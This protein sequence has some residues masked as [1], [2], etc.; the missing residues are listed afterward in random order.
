MIYRRDSYILT[1]FGR[2]M[3]EWDLQKHKIMQSMGIE[4]KCRKEKCAKKMN[5][6]CAEIDKKSIGVENKSH[7]GR[8]LIGSL[9]TPKVPK[10]KMKEV[11]MGRFRPE[12]LNMKRLGFFWERILGGGKIYF[13]FSFQLIF[14][15]REGKL[16]PKFLC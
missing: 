1:K 12:T 13:P 14:K 8:P 9:S 15:I 3:K 10:E 4:E 5:S 2:A 7:L 11:N 16:F 6:K